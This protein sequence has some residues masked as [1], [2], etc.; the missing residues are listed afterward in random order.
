MNNT[1]AIKRTFSL[2]VSITLLLVIFILVMGIVGESRAS[3]GEPSQVYIPFAPTN[4]RVAPVPELKESIF[5]EEARCPNDITYNRFSDTL[6]TANEETDDISIIR[7]GKLVTTI[8]TGNWPIHIQSDP[9]SD[10][11]YLSHVLGGIRVLNGQNITANLPAFGEAY[12]ILVNPVNGYTYITDLQA[13]INIVRGYEKVMDLFVPD[14]Q[15]D[16]IR[17]Q[18]ATDYDSLT[19]LTYFASWQFRAMTV[20][21]GTEVVDQFSFEGEGASDLVVDPYRRVIV[22]ANNRAFHDENLNNISIIDMNTKKVTPVV[23]ALYSYRAALDPVTGYVYVTNSEDNTVTILRG[24][25]VVGTFPTGEFP[26]EVAVDRL[27]GLAYITNAED[28]SI[29]VFRDGEFLS[30]IELPEG[31]GFKP[32]DLTIDE[33]TGRV[34]VLNRSTVEKHSI[35]GVDRVICKE[36]WVHILE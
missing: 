21:D 9:T 20:V 29:S 2:A 5:L 1:L 13:P 32:W 25:Q 8:P 19:G 28:N 35:Q 30:V 36:P 26:R 15:G 10:K 33:E 3:E 23:S 7:D 17:W 6:Y 22:V 12:N 27:R 14:F 18:L 16:S 34:F 31:K 24:R 11:V 4:A